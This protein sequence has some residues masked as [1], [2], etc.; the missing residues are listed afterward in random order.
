MDRSA[1]LFVILFLGAVLF[2]ALAGAPNVAL[3][4]LLVG[5]GMFV[6]GAV[7]EVVTVLREARARRARWRR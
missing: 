2:F 6:L 1:Q 5:V 3:V 7:I 4:I